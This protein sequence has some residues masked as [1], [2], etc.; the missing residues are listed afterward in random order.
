MQIWDNDSRNQTEKQ[1]NKIG[2]WKISRNGIQIKRFGKGIKRKI[3]K[4]K[5]KVKKS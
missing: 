5:K 4:I 3:E 2:K 1:V